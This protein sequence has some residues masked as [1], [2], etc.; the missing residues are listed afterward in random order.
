V[1]ALDRLSTASGSETPPTLLIGALPTAG[2]YL[3][4]NVVEQLLLV[5]G[6]SNAAARP[7]RLFAR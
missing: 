5:R 6:A 4:A 3:L 2:S 1:R 7:A